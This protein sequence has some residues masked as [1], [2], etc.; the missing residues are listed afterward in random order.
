[1]AVVAVSMPA[2]PVSVS[3]TRYER[4]PRYSKVVALKIPFAP[5]AELV[6]A[7]DRDPVPAL[8]VDRFGHYVFRG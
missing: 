7:G 2:F 4:S 5:L 1:M 6:G 3:R 8:G